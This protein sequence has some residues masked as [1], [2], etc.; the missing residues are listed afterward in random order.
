MIKVFLKKESPSIPLA[1]EPGTSC[2]HVSY[3]RNMGTCNTSVLVS[4]GCWSSDIVGYVVEKV[5][6]HTLEKYWC[7]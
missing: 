6:G 4:Y 3:L 2:E 5:S 7:A 1:C